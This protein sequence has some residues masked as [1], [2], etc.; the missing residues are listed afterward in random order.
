M[1]DCWEVT[2]QL[3]WKGDTPFCTKQAA[4]LIKELLKKRRCRSFFISLFLAAF[5]CS[6]DMGRA[7]HTATMRF[8]AIIFWHC[9]SRNSSYGFTCT[10]DTQLTLLWSLV[11]K[12]WSK[13]CKH[14]AKT[15]RLILSHL[16]HENTP[17]LWI[18]PTVVKKNYAY[19]AQDTPTCAIYYGQNVTQTP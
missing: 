13:H 1:H 4:D 8:S 19:C 2:E 6:A 18:Y 10:T 14:D 16:P 3:P 5:R 12:Q 17:T 7:W 11:I 15:D 9:L